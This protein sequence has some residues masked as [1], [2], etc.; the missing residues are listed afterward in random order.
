MG[1]WVRLSIDSP[2]T[3]GARHSIDVTRKVLYA[4]GKEMSTG[5]GAS[6]ALPNVRR[7]ALN[8][9]RSR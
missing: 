1:S 7:A 2:F 3:K 6:I 9:T 4:N 5:V 8:L